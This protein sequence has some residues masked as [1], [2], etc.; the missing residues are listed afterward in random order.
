V[1][2]DL[3]LA[4]LIGWKDC[5]VR[6][7]SRMVIIFVIVLPLAMTVVTGFAF[8]GFEPQNIQV[9]VGVVQ[10]EENLPPAVKS[11]LDRLENMADRTDDGTKLTFRR[12]ITAEQAESQVLNEEL[13][14]AVI[15]HKGPTVEFVLHENP[16]L[17]R[18]ILDVAF[19]RFLVDVRSANGKMTNA[20]KSKRTP[21]GEA[22]QFSSFT[23]AV[24]G[25]GVMFILLNCITAAGIGLVRERRQNTLARMLIAPLSR[26]TLLLGKTLGVFI[27]GLVQGIVIFSFGMIIGVIPLGKLPGVTLVTLLLILV[28]TALG[29]AISALCRREETV[30]AIGVPVSL[31]LTALG[32]GMF[33]THKAPEWMK[34]VANVLPTGWA[35]DAYHKLLR[36]QLGLAAIWPNLLILALFAALFFAIGLWKLR[37][38]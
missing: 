37:W 3:R 28:G 30:E 19:D 15:F 35:M 22:S 12:D 24:T 6:F 29:L 23:Q 2:L 38:E 26:T 17:E 11:A 8:K 5:L 14:G 20:V 9:R 16:T 21:V 4:W 36:E 31:V 1:N 13:H 32:G 27:I 10:E 34:G 33:P 25:N 7:Q 18:A